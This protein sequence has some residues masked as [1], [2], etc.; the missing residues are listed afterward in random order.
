MNIYNANTESEQLE[1]L[2][3][4]VSIIDKVKDIQSKIIVLG[5]GFN[6]IFDI[7]YSILCYI[8][9]DKKEIHV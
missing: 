9:F 6:V 5:G 8:I 2:S 4:L 3:D 7:K 1:T